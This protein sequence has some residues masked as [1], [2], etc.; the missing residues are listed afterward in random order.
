MWSSGGTVAS[1]YAGKEGAECLEY[2][3]C[4]AWLSRQQYTNKYRSVR[5]V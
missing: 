1:R 3:T 5:R 4:L 2:Y